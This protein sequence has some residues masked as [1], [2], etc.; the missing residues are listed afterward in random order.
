M[1]RFSPKPFYAKYNALTNSIWVDRA[2]KT[3]HL[4][5]D[6]SGAYGSV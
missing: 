2:V 4:P 6:S 5:A 3:M 1:N